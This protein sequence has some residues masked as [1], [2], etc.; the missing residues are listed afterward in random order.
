MHKSYNCN[1]NFLCFYRCLCYPLQFVTFHLRCFLWE[2]S[3]CVACNREIW[4]SAGL[5]PLSVCQSLVDGACSQIWWGLY[6]QWTAADLA[7]DQSNLTMSRLIPSTLSFRMQP[8]CYNIVWMF[9]S[10]FNLKRWWRLD[11]LVTMLCTVLLV[12][13]FSVEEVFCWFS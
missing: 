6:L 2:T 9:D 12:T 10:C 11:E 8:K 13:F 1:L 3:Q 7:R 5:P 4:L